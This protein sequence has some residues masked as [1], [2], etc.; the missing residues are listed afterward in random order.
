MTTYHIHA[1]TSETLTSR[2][3]SLC[4]VPNTATGSGAEHFY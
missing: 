2:I 4:E 1:I 3:Y